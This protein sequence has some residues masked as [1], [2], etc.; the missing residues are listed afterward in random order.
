MKSFVVI[1]MGR[2]GRAVATEL[3]KLGCEVLAVDTEEEN[4][5]YV[6]DRVT[7]AIVGDATDE[8]VLGSIGARNFDCAIVAM[9]GEDIQDS[10]LVT[11]MLK[12]MGM[13]EIICKA[14]DELHRKVLLKIGADRVIMPERDMGERLA[15]GLTSTNIIDVLE[16]SVDHS[17]VE[18]TPPPQWQ[19]RSIRELDVRASYGLN[20]M[21]VRT[22][23]RRRI[24]VSPTG[25]YVIHPEDVLIVVGDNKSIKRFRRS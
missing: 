4:V 25:D 1:G 7:H 15:M 3:Y 8:T 19:G 13:K 11:L 6:A 12:D 2:F 17:M 14:K 24:E 9:A 18:V 21:A 10:I 16:L 5:E 23:D 22:T 20:I